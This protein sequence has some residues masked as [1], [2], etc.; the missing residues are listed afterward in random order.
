M[1][2]KK[3]LIASDHGGYKLKQK[4][5]PFL[6]KKGYVVKDFGPHEYNP[7]DDYPDFI[8]PLAKKITKTNLGIII[9]RNG[10][11]VSIAANKI[12]GVRAATGFSEKMI[13]SARK[14]DNANIVSLPAD[15]ITETQAKRIITLFL[16]TPFS[17][18]PRHK[19]RLG[20]I[21]K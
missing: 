20:K 9:C 14:D 13:R 7:E 17:N 10:Q 8:L 11:G 3:I 1:K 21:P 19:R 12:K 18:A 2:S 5:I 15:Y 16:K 6:E 4:L